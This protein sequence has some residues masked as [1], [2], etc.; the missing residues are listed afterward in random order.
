MVVNLLSGCKE[1]GKSFGGDVLSVPVEVLDEFYKVNKDNFDKT[2]A[3]S[4]MRAMGVPFGFFN[5]QQEN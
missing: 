2:G 4:Y 1:L 3:R 5:K